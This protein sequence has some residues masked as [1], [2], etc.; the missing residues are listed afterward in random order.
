MPI[1]CP[2]LLEKDLSIDFLCKCS[3]LA[4]NFSDEPVP[5][6]VSNLLYEG[7]KKQK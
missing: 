3:L 2:L 6:I 5:V 1:I 7:F 4:Y